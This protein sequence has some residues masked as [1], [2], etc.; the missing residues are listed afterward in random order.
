MAATNALTFNGYINA[1]AALAIA[2]TQSVSGVQQ[3]VNTNYQAIIPQMLNYAE[4]RIQR[5][6]S[7]APAMEPNSYQFV[8]GNNLLVIP[9][10]DFVSVEALTVISGGQSYP[11]HPTS[12]FFLQNVYGSNNNPGI[13]LWFAPYGG[14][15]LTN[16][17]TSQIFMVGPW[18][19]QNYTVTATGMVRLPSLYQFATTA[20]AGSSTTFIS[21]WL[22]DLLIQASMIF[23]SQAQRNFGAASNDP[24]MGPSFELQYENLLKT[25]IVEEA[26]K[27]FQASGW[28][29]AE[30]AVVATADR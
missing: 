29:A 4:L 21:T 15:W 6:L 24:Q 28:T 22:P 16:G 14:D 26:R 12:K 27:K 7:L 13:P 9:T 25:A 10:A 11:L 2:N 19:D 1:I 3:F 20:Y 23:M 8:I 5:D 18:P 30:P 17:S